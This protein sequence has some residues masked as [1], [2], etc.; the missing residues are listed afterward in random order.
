MDIITYQKTYSEYKKE[1]DAELQRTTEGFVRIGYLLKVARDT[2]VLKESGYENVNDFARAEYGIDKT[3]VS[4]F[5]R[6]NDRFSEDE[7]SD[8]LK[9]QYQGFGYAKLAIMLQL[10]DFVNEE[11]SPAF[12]KS[13]VQAIKEEVDAENQVSDLEV[14][15][16]EKNRQQ[17]DLG[18]F[19]KVLH[20][21]GRD[22]PELYLELHDA[23]Q[24]ADMAGTAETLAPNGEAIHSVRIPGEGRKI[25]S[26]KGTDTRPVITDL[27]SGEKTDCSWEDFIRELQNLCMEPEGKTS[28]ETLYGQPFPVKEPEKPKVAPVQ[29]GKEEKKPVQRKQ[30]R[31]TKA[32]EEKPV[33]TVKPEAAKPERTMEA[34]EQ[35]E[36]IPERPGE[37]SERTGVIPDQNGEVLER[38]E[39]ILDQT[40][41]SPDPTEEDQIPGQME[42]EN[43]PEMIPEGYEKAEV[44]PVQPE[45]AGNTQPERT[46]GYLEKLKSELEETGRL[47]EGKYY[48]MAETHL[49]R[50]AGYL[51]RLKAIS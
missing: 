8:R 50:A 3:Q 34:P 35:P 1:L 48:E 32:K 21:L 6:I 30:P 16:E 4:R 15:M 18:I 38:S 33:K 28:W 19:G 9:I 14:L 45:N 23:A 49:E 10:P 22:N 44:A 25:L 26:I 13:E 46:S 43:Y 51:G 2:D 39:G 42:V 7:Y 47:A 29:Q 27:R 36:G 17:E 5:I 11:I 31:V 37:V 20:Q 24:N 40:G 41:E 12:S